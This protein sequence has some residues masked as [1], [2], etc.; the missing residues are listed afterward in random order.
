M[1][2]NCLM[3]DIDSLRRVSDEY[4]SINNEMISSLERIRNEYSNN[5]DEIISTNASLIYKTKMIDYLEKM[6][7]DIN[8]NNKYYINKLLEI[9]DIYKELNNEIKESIS[10]DMENENEK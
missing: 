6:C 9:V 10:I 8:K 1:N 7:M 5:F 3:V 4:E 2:D